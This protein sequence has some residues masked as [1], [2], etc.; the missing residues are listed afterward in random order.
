MAHTPRIRR[1]ISLTG[2]PGF[3]SQ[4]EKHEVLVVQYEGPADRGLITIEIETESHFNNLVYG[5]D[6]SDLYG[7]WA[8]PRT[9]LLAMMAEKRSRF[10]YDDDCIDIRSTISRPVEEL[11]LRSVTHGWDLEWSLYLKYGAWKGDETDERLYDRFVRGGHR[12]RPDSQSYLTGGT[13][14]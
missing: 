11:V 13:S 5:L 7:F 12:S 8:M 10:I 6:G 2:F 1:L 14:Y 4:L 3:Q 9:E